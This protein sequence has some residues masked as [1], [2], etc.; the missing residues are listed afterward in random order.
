VDRRVALGPVGR[1]RH[2]LSVDFHE[3]A[4]APTA[5][6]VRLKDIDVDVAPKTDL[7]LRNAPVLVGR[8]IPVTSPEGAGSSYAGPL[9]NAVTDT[10]LV[11]WHELRPA[12]TPGHRLLE[13]SVV[14]SNEDGGTDTPALMARWGRSTDVEWIYRVEVDERGAVVPGT[15]VY[16]GPDHVTLPFDGAVEG[17]HPVLQ[18]CTDNNMVCDDVDA[19][20][21]AGG[22][23]FF[24]PA[25]ETRPED[26]AR[27]LLM[28]QNPWTY[29]VTAAE[30]RREGR[31]EEPSDPGTPAVGDQ[32]TYLYVEVDRDTSPAEQ[33]GQVGLALQ[34]TLADGRTFRSDHGIPSWTITRDVP[35]ATTV[36]LPAGVTSADVRAIT[37]LRV[38]DRA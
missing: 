19:A 23:R 26:R 28:D 16:Q 24:L 13:Y 34:V 12:A 18:T 27:E 8:R 17:G 31:I 10:P 6:T 37:A 15:A 30:M 33:A 25:D 7:A 35:A 21:Q 11:A 1:G 32:R 20:S 4:S 14:W 9:Q 5:S 36:E 29:A 2:R 38:R 3:A 22:L